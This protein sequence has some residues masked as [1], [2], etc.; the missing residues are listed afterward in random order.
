MTETVACSGCYKPV[1]AESAIRCHAC[2]SQSFLYCSSQCET[3]DE[4]FHR[5]ACQV[6]KEKSNLALAE[7]TSLDAS[8][9]ILA[10][11]CDRT[12]W[13]LSLV[14]LEAHFFSLT[15]EPETDSLRLALLCAK[16]AILSRCRRNLAEAIFLYE[17]VIN[18]ATS[19]GL[20]VFGASWHSTTLEFLMRATDGGTFDDIALEPVLQRLYSSYPEESV[21]CAA[22]LLQLGKLNCR[23]K[24]FDTATLHLERALR[25]YEQTFGPQ[26]KQYAHCLTLLGRAQ[27]NV[28]A[29]RQEAHRHLEEATS[30][31]QTLSEPDQELLAI[32]LIYLAEFHFLHG[33]LSRF[34]IYPMLRKAVT[35]LE[36]T[37]GKDTHHRATALHLLGELSRNPGKEESEAEEWF[38]QEL[39]LKQHLFGGDVVSAPE[40]YDEQLRAGL[41]KHKQTHLYNNSKS[42]LQEALLI[43]EQLYGSNSLEWAETAYKLGELL[44]DE[45]LFGQAEELLNPALLL[46]QKLGDGTSQDCAKIHDSLGYL[47]QMQGQFD[48]SHK[49]YDAALSIRR[50]GSSQM[51]KMTSMIKLARSFMRLDDC[52]AAATLLSDAQKISKKFQKQYRSEHADLMDALGILS[53][54]EDRLEDAERYL[55]E[56]M[57]HRD[58]VDPD[59]QHR[60]ATLLK[61]GKLSMAANFK[62]TAE[63]QIAEALDILTKKNQDYIQSNSADRSDH[64]LHSLFD[65]RS[66]L[67]D[68]YLRQ[69]PLQEERAPDFF[70]HYAESLFATEFNNDFTGV[71][72]VTMVRH[73][74]RYM[75]SDPNLSEEQ[76]AKLLRRLIDM[77]GISP[78]GEQSLV[79]KDTILEYCH[80]AFPDL[81]LER[82]QSI[83]RNLDA[84]IF[85]SPDVKLPTGLW[86]PLAQLRRQW[87]H[88]RQR[89]VNE[90]VSNRDLS[91]SC[92]NVVSEIIIGILHLLDQGYGQLVRHTCGPCHAY[93]P[94]KQ[95]LAKF[96]SE[97]MQRKFKGT[98][99]QEVLQRLREHC[100]ASL[101]ADTELPVGWTDLQ[102][103]IE[104]SSSWQTKHLFEQRRKQLV[105]EIKTLATKLVD[106]QYL[107]KWDPLYILPGAQLTKNGHYKETDV[108]FKMCDDYSAISEDLSQ[109]EPHIRPVFDQ[110]MQAMMAK[111]MLRS[112]D[113]ILEA[114]TFYHFDDPCGNLDNA[115]AEAVYTIANDSK[116]IRL[117]PQSTAQKSADRIGQL[118]QMHVKILIEYAQPCPILQPWSFY[119]YVK[120]KGDFTHL[121]DAHLRLL[122]GHV[123]QMLRAPRFFTK[124]HSRVGPYMVPKNISR[125]SIMSGLSG[126]IPG[127][128]ASFPVDM[129]ELAEAIYQ[130]CRTRADRFDPAKR[131][132]RWMPDYSID[133]F[134]FV[135]QALNKLQALLEA[136]CDDIGG[137]SDPEPNNAIDLSTVPLTQPSFSSA[138]Q[139]VHRGVC[140][141]KIFSNTPSTLQIL[142]AK[143]NQWVLPFIHKA[144][145]ETLEFKFNNQSR[146]HRQELLKLAVTKF[147]EHG[148][149]DLAE[150]CRLRFPTE[151]CVPRQCVSRSSTTSCQPSLESD[152]T[153]QL[154]HC[155]EQVQ[156]LR[157][158]CTKLFAAKL[159]EQNNIVQTCMLE[160]YQVLIK[161]RG[162]V[163]QALGRSLRDIQSHLCPGHILL[164]AHYPV[165]GPD[166]IKKMIKDIWT[167]KIETKGS[168]NEET[169]YILLRK[170]EDFLHDIRFEKWWMAVESLQCYRN[171]NA[172]WAT[173]VE[174][175]N[176]AKHVCQYIPSSEE[177]FDHLAQ[178]STPIHP[179]MILY[180]QVGDESFTPRHWMEHFNQNECELD[181]LEQYR[182][183]A[184]IMERVSTHLVKKHWLKPKLSREQLQNELEEHLAGI[185]HLNLV[186]VGDIGDRLWAHRQWVLN[187]EKMSKD[188]HDRNRALFFRNHEVIPFLRQ[189]VSDVQTFL[190]DLFSVSLEQSEPEWTPA[191]ALKRN[192]N[193]ARQKVWSPYSK[194]KTA[195][196]SRGSKYKPHQFALDVA[197]A[198]RE[199]V[200]RMQALKKCRK[201]LLLCGLVRTRDLADLT[202]DN[203]TQCKRWDAK[204]VAIPPEA[205]DPSKIEITSKTFSS[206]T[207]DPDLGYRP[208]RQTV[209]RL[210][211]DPKWF[212]WSDMKESLRQEF[213]K[214]R[215]AISAIHVY[216]AGDQPAG[217]S[218]FVE[219]LL[220]RV[221]V[222]IIFPAAPYD[223]ASLICPTAY[224]ALQSRNW[225]EVIAATSSQPDEALIMLNPMAYM[226]NEVMRGFAEFE[227]GRPA[228]AL[229][230]YRNLERRMPEIMQCFEGSLADLNLQF[231]HKDAG[232]LEF[233]D[234]SPLPL[235]RDSAR[236]DDLCV[237]CLDHIPDV[238]T[239]CSHSFCPHCCNSW[240]L[241]RGNLCPLC[242]TLVNQLQWGE[243][244]LQLC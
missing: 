91:E 131:S 18:F 17:A 107:Q 212:G 176:K 234:K 206:K 63:R 155:D 175:T 81:E 158:M 14:C 120:H 13:K 34:D 170:W 151:K 183:C 132:P 49:H 104:A 12:D 203:L 30:L 198:V 164:Q 204:P 66:A 2:H 54:K 230:L 94:F 221:N 88:W 210:R 38:R 141:G 202:S 243:D 167:H 244:V 69:S 6:L 90:F 119:L 147:D 51:D 98:L 42:S 139:T 165:G 80:G 225:K 114:Q 110:I 3:A 44:A 220:R 233:Q 22:V 25:I 117:T 79:T 50:S 140:K 35:M 127:P 125:A 8:L 163:D 138:M 4:S 218:V 52:K 10:T 180:F 137:E 148:Y 16:S 227:N 192:N 242:R 200:G 149:R 213:S 65:V 207:Y 199:A 217:V 178:K 55:Y 224:D 122:S 172:W 97:M 145:A 48:E 166:R 36:M 209:T 19:R 157:W 58:S 238:T 60:A 191:N 197:Q 169:P 237:V 143:E 196:P 21:F 186:N 70:A 83:R 9:E 235:C 190:K 7:T 135:D 129:L 162:I 74:L 26:S 219:N 101:G 93:F 118:D 99:C 115:W 144:M 184:Q 168:V 95:S 152:L 24:Q 56:A 33:N 89:V 87:F 67:A 126:L 150:Q 61:L 173:A 106:P 182:T 102:E 11:I 27:S 47:H 205:A 23:H 109:S 189:A 156:S 161:L 240:F 231:L 39:C 15:S 181:L 72:V 96:E 1:I 62:G 223:S 211:L 46:T 100:K 236:D 76:K 86:E 239:H 134:E 194:P 59:S 121:T 28:E 228:A 171:A 146:F 241:P 174:I 222:E 111:P 105:K 68:L 103:Q 215:L 226:E 229:E 201:Q 153:S 40:N 75:S 130:F 82:Y 177:I 5:E 116:H 193:I 187:P 84:C 71:H 113:L 136:I 160:A 31:L 73:M 37:G 78:A 214:D 77:S 64:A 179:D 185:P 159:E 195:G 232:P 29:S 85:L 188:H 128:L 108:L 133:V 41:L 57:D 216:A 53:F 142:D 20:E 123:C 43:D 208:F 112:L 124:T 45:G 154:Q 92:S 32:S